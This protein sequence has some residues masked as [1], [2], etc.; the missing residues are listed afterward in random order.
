M[1]KDIPLVD[2]GAINVALK[3]LGAEAGESFDEFEAVGLGRHR[4]TDD[5]VW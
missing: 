4:N 2:R 1:P 5:W 3:F